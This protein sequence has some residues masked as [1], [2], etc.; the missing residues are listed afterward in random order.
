VSKN[1][2]SLTLQQ[3][4]DDSKGKSIKHMKSQINIINLAKPIKS[5]TS[6]NIS[7]NKENREPGKIIKK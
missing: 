4:N 1:L 7:D 2:I 6:F 3:R 5:H